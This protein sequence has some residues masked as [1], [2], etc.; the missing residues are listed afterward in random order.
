MP[1]PKELRLVSSL[2]SSATVLTIFTV[3]E[4]C[5]GLLDLSLVME[6]DVDAFTVAFDFFTISYSSISKED[7]I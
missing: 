3:E 7:V 1:N 5:Y 2:L 4:A 6:R